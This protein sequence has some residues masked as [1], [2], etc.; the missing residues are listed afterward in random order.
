MF[1]ARHVGAFEDCQAEQRQLM[2]EDMRR[3]TGMRR[4]WISVGS[5][6]QFSDF[7]GEKKNIQRVF[8]ND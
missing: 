7:C 6:V 3:R 5:L 2:D 1:L 8:R 4:A